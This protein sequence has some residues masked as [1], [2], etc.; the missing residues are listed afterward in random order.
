M[1]LDRDS[2]TRC[3]VLIVS[4]NAFVSSQHVAPQKFLFGTR[5]QGTALENF[6]FVWTP[7][8]GD[9]MVYAG[10]CLP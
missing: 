6:R 10:D 7:Y 9:A 4:S 3:S 2:S 5:V 8:N 1:A